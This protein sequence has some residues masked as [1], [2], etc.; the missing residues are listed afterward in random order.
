MIFA[1]T[2]YCNASCAFCGFNKSQHLDRHQLSLEDGIRAIDYLAQQNVRI[3]SFTGGEPLLNPNLEKFI[4]HATGLSIICRTG[5]NGVLLDEN[6]LSSLK[7]AGVSSM[8]FSIDSDQPELHDRNRGMKGLFKHVV[9]I[10]EFGES[11]GMELGAGVAISR[12]ITDY[13][14]LF[15]LLE[16]SGFRSVTFAYPSGAMDSSYLATNDDEIS[17]YTA[18]EL[19]SIIETIMAYKRSGK[20]KVGNSTIALQLMHDK[21][22][23]G[24]PMPKCF[25]GDK[26]FYLDW[27][28]E[29]HR[30]F[31][32]SSYGN[33]FNFNFDNIKNDDCD[34][35]F[36]QCFRDYSLFYPVIQNRDLVSS[37]MAWQELLHD[38]NLMGVTGLNS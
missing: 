31:T 9:K 34:K 25:A 8:W 3:M 24:I 38:N 2:S 5:T 15:R 7:K 27:N 21:L 4:E 36:S 26:I 28:L 14:R 23:K 30:C 29:L 16:D 1:I 18:S 37:F 22:T 20:I 6:R 32:L 17:R 12:L 19:A 13:N 33:L 10:R 11:I 35:C